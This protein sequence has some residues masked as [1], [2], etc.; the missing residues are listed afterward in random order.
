MKRLVLILLSG[1]LF[2][3]IIQSCTAKDTSFGGLL[4]ELESNMG[5]NSVDAVWRERRESWLADVRAA[6]TTAE[7]ATLMIEF[8]TYVLWTAVNPAWEDERARWINN[9]TAANND[10]ELGVC[11][12]KFESFVLWDVVSSNWKD[13]RDGWIKDCE[14]LQ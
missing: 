14:K 3:Q 2:S 5:W 9:C 10:K 7:K 8:E 6:S 13:R 1:I 12:M 11:L 4:I